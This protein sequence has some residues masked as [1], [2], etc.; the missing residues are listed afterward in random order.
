M[1]EVFT[2]I[3]DRLKAAVPGV[4]DVER[5]FNQLAMAADGTG[6]NIVFPACY[7]ELTGL[8][9]TTMPGGVQHCEGLLRIRHADQALKVSQL[10]TP[11]LEEDSYVALQNYRGGSI[12]VGLDRKALYPDTNYRGVEVI[13]S[14]YQIKYSD[15]TLAQKKF[16]RVSPRQPEAAD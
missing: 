14:E 7:V 1:K 4:K 10:R 6:T 13:V 11:Q 15:E 12:F 16:V 2:T 5:W 9:C 3:E 8:R